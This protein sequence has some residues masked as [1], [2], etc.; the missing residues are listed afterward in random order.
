MSARPGLFAVERTPSLPPAYLSARQHPLGALCPRRRNH[1]L[2]R[3]LAGQSAGCLYRPPG[4]TRI[5]F[6]GA[7]PHSA[8]FGLLWIGD[9]G[10]CSTARRS[11]PGSPWARS[12]APR[13]RAELRGRLLEQV[14]WADWSPDG[15]TLCVVRDLR[16]TKPNRISHR[17][18]ALPD[19][20]LD[21][22]SPSLAQ[23][24]SNRFRRPSHSGRR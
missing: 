11:A 22:A 10:V 13:C 4:S 19:R 16:R 17:T 1:S 21:R 9:G 18:I 12:P 15:N 7:Q 14:Q 6:H 23:R 20:R 2:Q 5:A 8:A 24:G 3:R